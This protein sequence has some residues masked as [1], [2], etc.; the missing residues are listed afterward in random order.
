MQVNVAALQSGQH[1][2][3][4]CICSA[5]EVSSYQC[6]S[7]RVEPKGTFCNWLYA[8]WYVLTAVDQSARNSA[9]APACIVHYGYAAT[10][11]NPGAEPYFDTESKGS[12]SMKL[13]SELRLI[14]QQAWDVFEAQVHGN[15][16]S[17]AQ[18]YRCYMQHSTAQHSTAQHSTAQ[19]STAQHSTAQ[20]STAQHSTAQQSSH[21]PSVDR[22]RS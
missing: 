6:C 3:L 18:V 11:N 17:K 19:H 21:V 1:P 4:M 22:I 8:V 10:A 9:N 15:D 16:D 20:H 13:E 7:G 12:S 5:T 14:Q 2:T